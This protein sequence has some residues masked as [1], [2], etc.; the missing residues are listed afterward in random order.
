MRIT[1]PSFLDTAKSKLHPLLMIEE[2]NLNN[3][4]L[5]KRVCNGHLRCFSISSLYVYTCTDICI[6]TCTCKH[7]HIYAY[8]RIHVYTQFIV[9][10]DSKRRK[11]K[12]MRFQGKKEHRNKA[13]MSNC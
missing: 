5:I 6:R 1:K 7:V 3:D 2:I 11:T 13:K 8:S 12:L 4:D 9:L 10:L